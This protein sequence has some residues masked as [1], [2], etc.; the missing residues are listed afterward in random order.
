MQTVTFLEAQT[1]IQQ[2]DLVIL[3]LSMPDCS[4]CHAVKPRVAQLF[5]EETFPVLHLDAAQYPE[6]AGTFQVMTA[7]AILVFFQGKEVHRQA[8]FIDFRKLETVV[9]N[10]AAFDTTTSLEDLFK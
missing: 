10:Y 3:Y 9:K 5:Q 6:V 1:A 7:P 4:V 8:R 2:N